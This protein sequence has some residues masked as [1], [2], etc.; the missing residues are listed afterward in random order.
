MA[1]SSER[2]IAKELNTWVQ[3]IVI[4]IAFIWGAYTFIY[5][6]I[7]LPKAAPVNVTVDLLLKKIGPPNSPLQK[8]ENGALI[9]IEMDVSAAN[10]SSRS[11]NLFPSVWF[12]HGY[13][14]RSIPENKDFNNQVISTLNSQDLGQIEKQPD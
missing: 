7:V 6:E 12:A 4:I 5:K 3:T 13:K 9:A 8:G 10:P 14:V 2:S 11:V 1:T